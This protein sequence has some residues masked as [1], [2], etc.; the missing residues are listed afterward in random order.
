VTR[1]RIVVTRTM[2]GAALAELAPLGDVDVPDED[3]ALDVGELRD[4]VRGATAVVTMLHDRVDDAFLAAAGP[5]LRVVANV[6]VGYDNVDLEACRRRGVV[7]TNT[8]G[9]LVD[10]TADLAMA[11]LLGVTRRV[12]EGDAL[13]RSGT[14]WTWS[15]TFMLGTGLQGKRLGLVGFGRIGQAVARRAAAFGMAVAYTARHEASAPGSDAV[16]LPLPELLAT[17]DV[18]SLHCPLTPETRHLVDR[19]ALRS[20][21]PEAFLVNTSR[22]PV[23]DEAALVEALRE[24]WIAGAALDVFER[25]PEVHPGL[26]SA[27]AVL[28][29]PHLG[30]ATRE[31]REAMALLAARNVSDVL[32]GRP[33]R[34]PVA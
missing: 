10:A 31:T 9:V 24:G 4:A 1:P 14:P 34:T 18:V 26:A 8:P 29:T 2:P 5:G 20:M 25:E 7:V 22:G 16:R 17:S 6:A 19:D 30:S 21:R 32:A 13:L 28:M 15:M 11:L 27:G 3:R 33:A 12:G 23:V